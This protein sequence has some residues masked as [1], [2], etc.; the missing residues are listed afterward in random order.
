LKESLLQGIKIFFKSISQIV[1]IEHVWTGVFTFLSLWINAWEWAFSLSLAVLAG[2]LIA[3][4]LRFPKHNIS[5]GLYGFS[6]G[7][8]GIAVFALFGFSWMNCLYIIIGSAFAA[9]MQHLFIIRNI[10][11]FTFP[12]ISIIWILS[13]LFLPEQ[14]IN[15]ESLIETPFTYKNLWDLGIKGIAQIFFQSKILS[16]ILFLIGIFI[17]SRK[18]ALYVLFSSL[19]AGILALLLK[20]STSD[21][22]MGIYGFNAALSAIV[23]SQVKKHAAL[24]SFLAVLITVF[25]QF[26]FIHLD[27]FQNLGGYF[28]FPFVLGTW[29]SLLIKRIVEKLVI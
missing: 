8:V 9:I 24:W 20:Q 11:G 1:L 15:L 2:N 29:I 28:T 23:F 14:E 21:I 22:Y 10:P 16:G 13:Y 19:F 26:T 25:V 18:I 17:A 27:T 5:K 7:L 12:F 6:P 4:L 3:I